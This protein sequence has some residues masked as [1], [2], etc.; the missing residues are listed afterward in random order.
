MNVT[1]IGGGI[2]GT[3]AAAR[4]AR[5]G[6]D[7]TL[8]ERG[9][10]GEGTTDD[11]AGVFMWQAVPADRTDHELKARSWETYRPLV[12]EGSIGFERIGSLSVAETHGHAAA[13]TDAA[14]DLRS[15]GLDAST[16]NP[17]ELREY[18]IDSG[19]YERGLFTPDDGYFDPSEVV[20]HFAGVAREAGATLRTGTEVTGVSTDRGAVVAVETDGGS[21]PADA[22]V[23]AAGP[24]APRVDEF[25]GVSHPLRHTVGPVLIVEGERRGRKLPFTLF[26]SKRYL[27][28]VGESGV[29]IGKYRTAYEDGELLDPD[30]SRSAASFR[31]E[32]LAFLAAAIPGLADGEIVD[33]WVGV[34]TVTP[35]GRP[36]VG[37]SSVEG[38]YVA[39]GMSGLGVTLAPVVADVLTAVVR[40]ESDPHA[41]VLS[42]DR[43]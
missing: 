12:S 13:L 5:A 2:V 11:S 14:S 16:L 41:A 38:F 26:E 21:I 18:G 24:W 27:R 9:D 15:F 35:D 7:V 3:A 4:L 28:S 6:A 42:P 17:D 25:V 1:V 23:N 36:I 30:E 20:D 10:L 39:A 22:V 43:F 33:K 29:F 19:G 37:E 40:G 31:E 32:G 34:R 8:L